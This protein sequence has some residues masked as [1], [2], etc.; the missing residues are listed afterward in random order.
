MTA[1]QMK[2]HREWLARARQEQKDY[3]PWKFVT[4]V[5]LRPLSLSDHA[6]ARLLANPALL[7]HAWPLRA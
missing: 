3:K 1:A 4:L 2:A 5:L 6:P 7:M